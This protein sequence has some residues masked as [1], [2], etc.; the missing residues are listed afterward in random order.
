MVASALVVLAATLSG[1]PSPSALDVRVDRRV[2]LLSLVFRLSGNDEY[3]QANSRSPYSNEVESHFGQ[4]RGHPVVQRA[5]R[6][7]ELGVGFDAPMSLAIHL[8]DQVP[9]RLRRAHTLDA[10]WPT[11]Q[12]D[13]FV[14]E[15][16]DFAAKSN[17]VTFF[18]QH[19][20][21]Y[22][23]TAKSFQASVGGPIYLDW[24]DSFFGRRPAT[25][26]RVV[27]SL[28]NGG[29]CYGPKIAL[30]DGTEEAYSILGAIEFDAVGVP[31]FREATA[32]FFVHEF[33]HSY[34]NDLVDQHAA[35]LRR[36]GE[37]L[38]VPFQDF[39]RPQGYGSGLTLLKESLVRASVVECQ[40][41]LRGQQQADRVLEAEM[42]RGF[43]WLKELT[44][45]LSTYSEQR[46]RYADFAAFMPE[47]VAFFE[48]YTRATLPQLL[49]RM[50]RVATLE[51]PNGTTDVDPATSVLKVAFDRRMRGTY[52]VVGGGDHYPEDAGPP[53]FDE[54]R[55]VFT[56]PVRLRPDWQ[57]EF[58]LNGGQY[59]AFKS[60]DG[61]PLQPVHV[62]FHTRH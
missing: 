7:H 27:I 38:Y 25:K 13:A 49:A 18:D 59:S 35:A 52:S 5:V 43:L 32:E 58:R 29:A 24:F 10:R 39:L 42:N 20:D 11:D 22:R 57:Y 30:E 33:V 54:T 44:R 41:V 61:I 4:F 9:F 45:L 3:N 36:A 37:S 19:R 26:Y 28:L 1:E 23:A 14:D 55:T 12:P 21:L 46:S 53:R 40:R 56:M 6:L 17:F 47:V 62:T 2:E 48:A 8:T 51:P 60:E 50:P 31:V 34:T 15:L 16:N